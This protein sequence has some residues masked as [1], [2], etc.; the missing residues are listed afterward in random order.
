M[1]IS[2][3][4]PAVLV[5]C[6]ISVADAGTPHERRATVFYTAQTHGVLEPCGCTSDPL[7]DIA[8]VTSLIRRSARRTPT[9]L[10]DAGDLLYPTNEIAPEKQESAD[11]IAGF[12]AKEM[13][14]LPFGGSAL[15]STDLVRGESRVVPKRLAANVSGLPFLDAG[16]VHQVGAIKIGVFGLVDPALAV[17]R[18]WPVKDPVLTAQIEANRLR[19][20]GAELVFALAPLDR[21]QA[22][23]VARRGTVDFVIL[24]KNVGH[25][26]PRAE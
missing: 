11:L 19:S 25:G 4:I 13:S 6:H 20:E 17:S 10:L 15:G 26:S 9:L 8:R 3:A 21:P 7:G 12:L 24:G 2:V 1:R 5:F 18:G 14:L 23:L 16:R 22:R